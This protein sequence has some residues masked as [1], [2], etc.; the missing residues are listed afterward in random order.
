MSYYVHAYLQHDEAFLRRVTHTFL[1]RHPAKALLSYYRI[2]PDF[3]LEEVGLERQ[4]HHFQLVAELT[5][6]APILLDADDLISNPAGTLRAYCAALGIPFLPQALQWQADIPDTW[7][8]WG[9][10]LKDVETSTGFRTKRE[11]GTKRG[12]GTETSLIDTVP[13]L[14]RYY[15]HHLPFYEALYPCLQ[16]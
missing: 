15:E 13:Q 12:N 3:L 10:W 2:T 5:G 7:R 11:N 6:S 4:Y 1:I 14:R 16:S 9:S 8:D